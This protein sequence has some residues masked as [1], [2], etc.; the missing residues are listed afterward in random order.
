MALSVFVEPV[1]PTLVTAAAEVAGRPTSNLLNN[2]PGMKW[3][4]TTLSTGFVVSVPA[5]S[6]IDCIA[7]L[8]SNLRATDT[9]RVRAANSAANTTASPLYDSGNVA[10][11]SGTKASGFSTKSII[12]LPTALTHTHWRVDIVASGHPDGYV[13]AGKVVLGTQYNTTR[14]MDY[15][16]KQLM[17][18][19][20]VVSEGP[21]YED[22][23]EYVSL[24]GWTASFSYIPM[25]TWRDSF[26]PFLL[27]V[28][29]R[30]PVLFI[31]EPEAP[32]TWQQEVVYGRMKQDAAGECYH[33]DGWKT[34][35]TIL[36]LAA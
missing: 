12:L 7:L 30:K 3:R 35:I 9:I 19:Q 33:W 14:D 1:T 2:E 13:E 26:Y 25:T 16:C 32:T 21:G 36:G 10:A 24:P 20:S 5:G 15:D 22:V 6:S 8:W 28:G 29:N 31:P 27:R 11:F 34:D 23:D 4:S 18:N 17:R